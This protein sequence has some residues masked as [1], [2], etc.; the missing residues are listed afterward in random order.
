ME[1]KI[2]KQSLGIDVDAKNLKVCLMQLKNGGLKIKGKRNFTNNKTGFEKLTSWL[3][4]KKEAE[5]SLEVQM[6]A[7]GVYYE[8]LAYYLCEIE[9]VSLHVV[10]PNVASHYFKSLNEKSKTDEIDARSLAQLGVERTLSIWQRADLG[11]RN[12]KKLTRERMKLINSRTVIQNQIHAEASSYQPYKEILKR[13][14]LLVRYINKQ[15]DQVEKEIKKF[16]KSQPELHQKVENISLCKGLGFISIVSIIAET[17]CFALIRNK[18]Q[19]VSYAGYDVVKKE[20]GSSIRGKTR[21]SKKG[22]SFIRRILYMPALAACRSNPHYKNHYERI[23]N[24]SAVKMKGNVAVQRKLLLLIYSL[25]KSGEAYDP[26]HHQ[27]M[28]KKLKTD[29]LFEKCSI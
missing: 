6:E 12:L 3:L 18:N 19:L 8:N 17:N 14:K 16:V 11:I 1:K 13:S 27:K 4:N 7:T 24:K 28:A 29:K 20:S 22:N 25:Y 15:I 5:L 2:T 9:W 21:I 23:R 26:L 10:L